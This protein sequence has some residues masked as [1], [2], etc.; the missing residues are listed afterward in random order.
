[1]AIGLDRGFAAYP[2][3]DPVIIG[4]ITGNGEL[5]GLDAQRIA[6]EAV[7]LDP[8]EI[9]PLVQALRLADVDVSS[10][11]RPDE[12]L[13]SGDPTPPAA[14]YGWFEENYEARQTRSAGE[15]NTRELNAVYSAL[16]VSHATDRLPVVAYE[17]VPLYGHDLPEKDEVAEPSWRLTERI[18]GVVET[19]AFV[20]VS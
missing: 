17:W 7:G 14:V 4:D 5:G 18:S 15:P 6:Q 9:P 16:R 19:V 3:V 12:G 11:E 10:R 8:P 2:N 13:P 1:V 20:G